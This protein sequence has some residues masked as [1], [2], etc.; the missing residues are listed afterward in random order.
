MR[1]IDPIVRQVDDQQRRW[2]PRHHVHQQAEATLFEVDK[3]FPQRQQH[4]Q[5]PALNSGVRR[6]LLGVGLRQAP[7]SAKRRHR[8]ALQVPAFSQPV[9][10]ERLGAPGNKRDWFCAGGWE[11][12]LLSNQPALYWRQFLPPPDPVP[13]VNP[14]RPP[15][16]ACDVLVADFI[17]RAQFIRTDAHG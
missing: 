1:Q 6:P 14:P 11:I 12:D 8:A 3:P 17:A 15:G 4:P 10:T 9:A 2:L 7:R 16:Q 13:P 5:P